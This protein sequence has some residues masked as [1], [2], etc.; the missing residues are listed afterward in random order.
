MQ[1]YQLQYF[2][3]DKLSYNTMTIVLFPNL[4]LKLGL[5]RD[6]QTVCDT[7]TVFP[8]IVD[9]QTAEWCHAVTNRKT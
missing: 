3:L 4:V 7:L 2:S 1:Q 6:L 5:D 8:H 9:Q